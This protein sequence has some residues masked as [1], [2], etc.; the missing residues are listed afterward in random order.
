M[1]GAGWDRLPTFA[2][3][4]LLLCLGYP[5]TKLLSPSKVGRSAEDLVGAAASAALELPLTC[6]YEDLGLIAVI[7]WGMKS[8]GV[9]PAGRG[10]YTDL[11][12]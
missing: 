1:S 7:E 11:Y 3:C 9:L 6:S 8:K 10:F 4:L 2:S 5:P 12:N